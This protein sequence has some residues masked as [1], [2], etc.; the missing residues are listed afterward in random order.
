MEKWLVC[1][2]SE[3]CVIIEMKRKKTWITHFQGY[4]TNKPCFQLRKNVIEA[5]VRETKE[6]Y[7]MHAGKIVIRVT[8]RVLIVGK[9]GEVCGE[10]QAKRTE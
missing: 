2:E 4:N 9:S 5:E 6:D 3:N 7:V 10:I 8:K 1:R